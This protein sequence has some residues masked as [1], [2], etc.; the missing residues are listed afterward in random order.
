MSAVFFAGCKQH[1]KPWLFQTRHTRERNAVGRALRKRDPG[2]EQL[3]ALG[4]LSN[5]SM[6]SM[7]PV[8]T[9]MS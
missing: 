7:L 6:A 8:N 4:D 1:T 3:D 5:A 2:D 9:S